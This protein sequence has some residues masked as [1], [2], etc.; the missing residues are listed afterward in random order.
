MGQGGAG[1]NPGLAIYRRVHSKLPSYLDTSSQKRTQRL[2]P[3]SALQRFNPFPR[4]KQQSPDAVLP[5]L[6]D[7]LHFQHAELLFGE[8]LAIYILRIEVVSQLIPGQAVQ[9]R[10]VGHQRL[11][12]T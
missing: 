5:V 12:F 8:I 7:L 4:L 6:F 10:V 2:H 11:V 3:N 1:Q 9:V